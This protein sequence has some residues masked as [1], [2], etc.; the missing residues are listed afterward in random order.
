L[1]LNATTTYI[2][3]MEEDLHKIWEAEDDY[4]ED[5]ERSF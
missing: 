3:M 1:I 2:A 4:I 5:Y